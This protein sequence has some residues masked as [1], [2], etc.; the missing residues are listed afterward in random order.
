[1][2]TA[3]IANHGFQ[4]VRHLPGKFEYVRGLRCGEN[5]VRRVLAQLT[6]PQVVGNRI[7][8]QHHILADETDMFPQVFQREVTNWCPVQQNHT[9]VDIIKPR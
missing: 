6:I 4:A 2:S 7:V 1:V 8:E 3:A 9:P 5:L